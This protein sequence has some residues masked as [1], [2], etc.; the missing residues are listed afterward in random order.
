MF[1]AMLFTATAII[2]TYLLASSALTAVL[3]VSAL[4]DKIGGARVTG[5]GS[6]L[7]ESTGIF[8]LILGFVF[9]KTDPFYAVHA[10]V[11]GVLLL[12]LGTLIRPSRE[13]SRSDELVK[14][15]QVG[16]YRAALVCIATLAVFQSVAP[17]IH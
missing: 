17:L 3:G 15:A 2:G 8:G 11:I 5:A 1:I 4:Y 13:T 9:R 14:R 10:M 6:I 7:C 12:T 16:H